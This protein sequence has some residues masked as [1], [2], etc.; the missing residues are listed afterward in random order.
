VIPVKGS[1]SD[2]THYYL[3]LYAPDLIAAVLYLS[4][5]GMKR[6]EIAKRLDVSPFTVRNILGL[7]RRGLIKVDII[8]TPITQEHVKPPAEAKVAIEVTAKK[9]KSKKRIDVLGI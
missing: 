4:R 9:S 5:K 6:S 2:N 1:S 8:I 7:V 3:R